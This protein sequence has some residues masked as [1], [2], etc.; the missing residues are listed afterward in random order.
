M[1]VRRVPEAAE[2]GFSAGADSY[3]RG[4]PSYPHDAVAHLVETLG[5]KSSSTV[6]DLAAGTGKLTRLLVP[7]GARIVAVEP[8]PA[9]RT[10]LAREVSGVEVIDGVAEE[11][12]LS[13]RS[14][15]V[16]TIAQAF[17]WFRLP[18]ALEE[19][20]RVLVPGGGLS[21]IWN[22]RDDTL[23]WVAELS[24]I[25]DWD[26]LRPYRKDFDP[27]AILADSGLFRPFAAAKFRLDQELDADGL[28]DRVLSTSYLAALPAVQREG[29][30][31]RVR[32]LV[33]DF[34][35]RFLLPYVTTVC[36]ALSTT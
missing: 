2:A 23:P 8:L 19:V 1:S 7:S 36:C 10:V 24:K 22:E 3:E 16:V 26:N 20:H 4:R 34:P 11:I 21:I 32:S 31:Q 13:E 25:I 29:Y 17:H 35:P 6:I 28:V 18:E 15:D 5:I 33:S 9:M 12:P 30:S 14:A 27:V